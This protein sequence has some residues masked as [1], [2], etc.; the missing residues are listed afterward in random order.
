MRS[1]SQ[2]R[3]LRQVPCEE[4]QRPGSR[5][6]PAASL[7]QQPQD[8]ALSTD[9]HGSLTG[10]REPT[11]CHS[12]STR[13]PA[14]GERPAPPTT[15]CKQ[16]GLRRR[17]VWTG[18]TDLAGDPGELRVN[19]ARSWDP[20]PDLLSPPGAAAWAVGDLAVRQRTAVSSQGRE[21]H[22]KSGHTRGLGSGSKAPRTQ[23]H[24]PHHETVTM[25]PSGPQTVSSPVSYKLQARVS[26]ERSEGGG[27][28][29][30]PLT[31]LEES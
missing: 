28:A 21:D 2:T 26:R 23:T 4:A 12:S 16:N 27:G 31:Q 19:E 13:P 15:P 5:R 1:P 20:H 17:S 7:S 6:N 8:S 3:P 25:V 9:S 14:C 24:G 22:P 10:R 11:A 18:R 30:R 29:K